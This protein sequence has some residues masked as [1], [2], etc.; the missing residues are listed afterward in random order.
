MSEIVAI[1][2]LSTLGLFAAIVTV[3]WFLDIRHRDR[4]VRGQF[5]R[6]A[7]YSALLMTAVAGW[8]TTGIATFLYGTAFGRGAWVGAS[9]VLWAAYVLW[10]VCTVRTGIANRKRVE[11]P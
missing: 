8:V 9:A 3:S 1:I 11:T 5:W 7:V 2:G 10:L 4:T 6:H